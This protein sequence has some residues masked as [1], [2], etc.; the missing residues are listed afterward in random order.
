MA[1]PRLR[2]AGKTR[3]FRVIDAQERL[4][5]AGAALLSVVVVFLVA[6]VL[7][8]LTPGVHGSN[9]SASDAGTAGK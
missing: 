2:Y 9:F 3:K 5:A 1:N 4:D 8:I 6:T 7:L